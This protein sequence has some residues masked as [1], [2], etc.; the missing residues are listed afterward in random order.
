M[1]HVTVGAATATLHAA[2]PPAAQAAEPE[3]MVVPTGAESAMLIGV[4]VVTLP[5]FFTVNV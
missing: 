4:G 3:T 1:V 2:D 5:V